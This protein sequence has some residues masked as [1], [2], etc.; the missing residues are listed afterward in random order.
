[1]FGKTLLC[2]DM[3]TALAASRSGAY[4][5]VTVDGDVV[6]KRGALTGGWLDAARNRLD[7]YR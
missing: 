1:M 3:D 6:S 4:N 5:C 2:K 7:C